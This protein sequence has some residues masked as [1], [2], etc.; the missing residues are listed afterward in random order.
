LNA[1]TLQGDHEEQLI[2]EILERR[3]NLKKLTRPVV[4]EQDTLDVSFAVS[5]HQI[6]KV[7]RNNSPSQTVTSLLVITGVVVK[8]W[9][10]TSLVWEGRGGFRAKIANT[11]VSFVGNLQLYTL[12]VYVPLTFQ[13]TTP[14]LII[15]LTMTGLCRI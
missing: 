13:P 11:H 14:L 9:G 5:L 12:Y 2:R 7:V 15:Q 8:I 1:G 6:V 10:R 4:E 3:S